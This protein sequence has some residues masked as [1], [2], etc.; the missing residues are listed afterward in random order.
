MN[1]PAYMKCIVYGLEVPQIQI[2]P[3]PKP[4][5]GHILVRVEA[6]GLNPVDA[7]DVIGDKLPST[8]TYTRSWLRSNL[9]STKIPGFD[10]AGTCVEDSSQQNEDV[11]RWSNGEKVFGTMPPLQGT[12]AEFISVPIDQLITMPLNLKFEEAAALP[13]V[14]YVLHALSTFLYSHLD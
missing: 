6:V 4:R 1:L 8:W 14:G 10:F 11:K 5:K 9:I 12:L 2:R 3:T 7:K 13:L